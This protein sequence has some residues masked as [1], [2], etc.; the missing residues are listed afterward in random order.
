[1]KKCIALLLVLTMLMS[2][3]SVFAKTTEP[4]S[5]KE[6]ISFEDAVKEADKAFDE[7]QKEVE[8]FDFLSDYA[9]INMA[10]KLMNVSI[11]SGL[12][13]TKNE[14][15]IN[16]LAKRAKEYP[17]RYDPIKIITGAKMHMQNTYIP[18]YNELSAYEKDLVNDIADGEFTKYMANIEDEMA[19]MAES[20]YNL[21]TPKK[22]ANIVFSD[23]KEENWYYDAVTE[24]T[25]MGLFNGKTEHVNGVGT[26]APDDTITEVEFLAILCR[27]IFDGVKVDTEGQW[28]HTDLWGNNKTEIETPWYGD[29]YTILVMNDV[30]LPAWKIE[31]ISD[32]QTISRENMATLI[33]R[34]IH[35]SRCWSDT[36]YDDMKKDL[37]AIVADYEKVSEFDEV[38]VKVAYHTGIMTGDENGN[39]TPR[40]TATRAEAA[41]VLY[42]LYNLLNSNKN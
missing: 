15:E 16:R 27:M 4:L 31:G 2:G 19:K 41:A 18:N 29:Y 38:G 37:S 17:E 42:R 20:K 6:K 34:A 39:I 22:N 10:M 8:I 3:A 30:Y 12:N 24:M 13:K 25:A 36:L 9:R 1:M 14:D 40:D 21:T 33:A 28:Y 5:L 35:V 23:V 11:S 32:T 7:V 26:F